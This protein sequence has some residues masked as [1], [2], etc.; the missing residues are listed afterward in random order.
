MEAVCNAMKSIRAII[1]T[2]NP[3]W[4]GDAFYVR[5]VFGNLAFSEDLSPFLMFDYGYPK[6]F[7]ATKKKT[8]SRTTSSSWL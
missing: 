2:Q 7:K 8:W 3:H 1:P 5:P 6:E 4:V